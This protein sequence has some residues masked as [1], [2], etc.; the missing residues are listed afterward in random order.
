MRSRV[1]NAD[2]GFVYIVC[3]RPIYIN[4]VKQIVSII[5]CR[6]IIRHLGMRLQVH[7]FHAV[8]RPTRLTSLLMTIEGLTIWEQ[9]KSQFMNFR[10][11]SEKFPPSNMYIYGIILRLFWCKLNRW[12]L[13]GV[14]INISVQ[15]CICLLYFNVFTKKYHIAC[16]FKYEITTV[17]HQC[18]RKK[19]LSHTVWAAAIKIEL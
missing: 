16:F 10:K 12:L 6:V 15:I 4:P 3:I 2:A 18:P 17:V 7:E 5:A 9:G 14:G 19:Q 8:V 11:T 13:R 1:I